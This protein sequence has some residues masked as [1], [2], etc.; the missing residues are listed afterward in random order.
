MFLKIVAIL[1]LLSKEGMLLLILFWC[2]YITCLV[3][4]S[5]K[6]IAL[7]SKHPETVP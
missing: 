6:G 2:C 4:N 7:K 1:Y 5:L 3:V